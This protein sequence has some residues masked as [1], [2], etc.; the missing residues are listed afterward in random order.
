M[1]SALRGEPVSVR[2][3]ERLLVGYRQADASVRERIVSQPR[4]Y[5]RA[6]AASQPAPRVPP[7]DPA[8]P[9][10][11]EL[12]DIAG[13]ARRAERRVRDGVLHELDA[14]RRVLV[15]RSREAAQ[16]TF[17]ALMASLTQ[18]APC[19]TSTPAPRS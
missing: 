1:V 16:S 17:E 9:L 18:E 11:Q 19:S 6:D 14:R 10:L 5:L 15:S 2:Q 13:L 8:A 3:I 12:H 4:L 7:R